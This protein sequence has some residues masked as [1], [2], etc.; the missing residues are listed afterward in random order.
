[1]TR[2]RRPSL[3]CSTSSPAT[4]ELLDDAG[5]SVEMVIDETLRKYPPA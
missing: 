5:I 1:M 4:P 2:R 3:S